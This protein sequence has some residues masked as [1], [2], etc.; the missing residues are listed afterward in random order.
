MPVTPPPKQ[1]LKPT[2]ADVDA[3]INRGGKVPTE[4]KPADTAPDDQIKQI[5]ARLT[6]SIIRQIDALRSR[7]PRK[8]GSPKK[9][10][11]LRDWIVEACLE[12]L[13][14]DGGEKS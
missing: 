5:N 1:Q 4:E 7:R 14:R 3:F 11:S 6:V 12:K 2:E 10:V 9:G 8:I 13:E